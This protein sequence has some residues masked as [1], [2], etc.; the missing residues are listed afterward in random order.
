VTD[1]LAGWAAEQAPRLRERAEA[2][3][4]RVLR[5]ALVAAA[6]RESPEAPAD[7]PPPPPAAVDRPPAPTPATAPAPAE[8]HAP[9]DAGELL[10]AYCV[11]RAGDAEPALPDGLHGS[12]PVERVE[13]DG[14]AM[15][16]SRVPRSEFG[17][18]ALQRN[19]N[20]MPWLERT[21]REHEAVLDAALLSATI[22]PLR[23]C[24]VYESAENA[25]RMLAREKETLVGALG[26]LEGRLEWSVKVLAARDALMEIAGAELEAD[27][28]QP[29]PVEGHGEGGAYMLRRRRE[30]QLRQRAQSIAADVAEQVHARLQD[31][32]IDAVTR[33]AQNPE[34]SGHEGEMLLNAA[35]LVEREQTDE[36]RRLVDEL[37]AHHRELGITIE[38]TGPWPPYNFVP[39]GDARRLT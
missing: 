36:L 33:P 23:M 10:W 19:L 12:G 26:F 18:G 27:E 6:L 30:R 15:I 13:A 8:P 29:A 7:P 39:G 1:E 28:G 38:L 35:Y 16:V 2:E 9:S 24:T 20:D 25:T 31:W 3:A 32:A 4:V 34:L 21:A 14:L 17:S 5:D 22:V 11:I 37:E